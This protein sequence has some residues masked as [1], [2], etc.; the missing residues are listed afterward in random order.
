[1]NINNLLEISKIERDINRRVQVAINNRPSLN[2]TQRDKQ[3]P[4]QR[5]VL[6]VINK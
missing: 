2:L 6:N 3:S 5:L 4:I 1:M